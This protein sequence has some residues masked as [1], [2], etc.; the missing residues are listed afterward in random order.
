MKLDWKV[1]F[2]VGLSIFIL[3]IC[4]H[5]LDS[6]QTL[7]MTLLGAAAP[8]IIG[9]MIAYLVN[10][11][12]TFYERYFFPKAKKTALIKMRRPLCMVFAFL[13]LIAIIVLIIS[14]IVPQLAACVQLIFTSLTAAVDFLIN[15]VDNLDFIPQN[16]ADALN[17]IDWQSH[18]G[19]IVESLSS[20]VGNV[21]SL[22][23]T[24]V[25][26]VFS[27]IVSTLLSI[28]FSIYLL[29]SKDSL[30]RQI[31]R[32]MNRYLKEGIRSKISYLASVIDDCFH[33]YIVGQCIE[34]VILG[35]LCSLGMLLLGIPYAP[36]IGALVGFTALIPVAGAYI[37]AIIGAFILLAV[38]PVKALIFT[39]FLLILQQL[40]GNLIYPK[41]VGKSI[42]LPGLWVL[43]A[44]TVG[45]G[46][47]G[48]LGMLLGVPLAA[49]AYRLIR[50]DVNRSANINTQ[51]EAPFEES[52]NE[53][54]PESSDSSEN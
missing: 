32:I 29:L 7:L 13:T 48:V 16:V 21:L 4:I 41:V 39:I 24:T 46:I 49:A 35:A 45:G 43:A 9:C 14:L 10:I 53:P 36:T 47:L 38:S 22:V 26:Y 1:C 50:E 37:G 15:N 6:A 5:Y 11:L 19:R 30:K 23:A 51:P 52:E 27:T 17:Q 40:E 44:V 8:L 3:Y 25:T 28:I 31:K 12:M 18:L 34:A 20:G 33:S 42:G 54:S 2:K